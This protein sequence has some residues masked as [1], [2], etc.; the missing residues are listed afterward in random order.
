LGLGPNDRLDPRRLA[1]HIGVKVVELSLLVANGASSDS[2]MHFQTAGQSDFSAVTVFRESR[3]LIIINEVHTPARQASSLAH[4][5]S[6]L[7]LKHPP[8]NAV[9]ENGCRLAFSDIE[10]EA[11]YLASVLLVPAEGALTAARKGLPLAQAA[12]HFGVSEPMMRWRFNDTHAL[13]RVEA[14]R[15]VARRRGVRRAGGTR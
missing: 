13:K 14:E 15:A 8:H 3:C 11:D 4:E 6:H 12:A 9:A 7:L 10:R 2:V 1:L 5:L